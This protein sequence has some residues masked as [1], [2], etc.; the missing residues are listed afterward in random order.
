MVLPDTKT[1]VNFS[2]PP[3]AGIF[4]LMTKSDRRSQ[5]NANVIGIL[6]A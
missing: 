2:I 1:L 5:I 4:S 3:D 6:V